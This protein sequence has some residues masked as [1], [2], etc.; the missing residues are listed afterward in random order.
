MKKLL[1]LI[2][3]SF[4]SAQGLAG[5]CPDGSEPV[6]SV[7]ADGTYFVY[8][9]GTTNSNPNA[10]TVKVAM[11]PFNG[12]WMNESI[13]PTTL[14]ERLNYK[15]RWIS[16]IFYGDLDNDGID[17]LV[18]LAT[19]KEGKKLSGEDVAHITKHE[20]CDITSTAFDCYDERNNIEIYTIIDNTN[21]K[22]YN[23][24]KQKFIT[25][26]D[27]FGANDISE[28]LVNNNPIEMNLQS[29]NTIKLADFNGDGV[30]DIF[31][32]DAG[33]NTWDGNTN[34]QKEKN[35]LYYLSQ[36]NGAWLESTVTHVTGHGVKKGRGLEN[37]SHQATVGDIDNDGDIDIVV[38]S[39][40]WVGH[41]GEIL[42]Y[43]NQGDGHMV[44]RRCGD[45][46]GFEV[47]LGDI[48]NDGDLDIVTGG[49]LHNA[50][51]EWGFYNPDPQRSFHGILLNDGTGNFYE[52]GFE[53]PE[54]KNSNGFWYSTVPNISVA[55]LDGDGD[56][57]VINGLVGVNY[58]GAAMVI[59]ENIGN[60]QFRTALVDEWCRGPESKEEWQ[61]TEGGRFGCFSI[62]LKLGDFNKD[63]FVDIVVDTAPHLKKMFNHRI[64]DG[65][66]FLSTGKFTYDTIHPDDRK[67][68][69]ADVGDC[70][71]LTKCIDSIA[72]TFKENNTQQG[73]EDELAAFEAELA[74]ELG[75]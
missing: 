37:Y 28:R 7:S 48:D 57:D 3:L 2:I 15:Y 52:R 45:Q 74:A 29:P 34:K 54:H 22:A 61:P 24:T 40:R 20:V 1:L 19:P 43:V 65:T 12:D 11:K 49:S 53:F 31:A 8:N 9:C 68:P 47:E 70:S 60:G 6:K 33:L 56:L 26:S 46:W 25:T 10:G 59:E 73:I 35:D 21:F 55:D 39:N 36:P 23:T 14:K 63:G 30:L 69:F 64:V 62:G 13:F 27:A 66:V 18:V 17:D 50:M 67:Y 51:E 41:N 72:G 58:A 16:G 5:E 38:P 4:F 32:S 75:E 71:Y 42:C 44:V